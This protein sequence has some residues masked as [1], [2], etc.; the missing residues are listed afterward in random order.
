MR[1]QFVNTTCVVE[2]GMSELTREPREQTKA[3]GQYS[4]IEIVSRSY[5]INQD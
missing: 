1:C 4:R 5:G 3:N 2:R